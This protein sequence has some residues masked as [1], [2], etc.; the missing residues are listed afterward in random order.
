MFQPGNCAILQGPVAGAAGSKGFKPSFL[1]RKVTRA[2]PNRHGARRRK[3][4]AR[5]VSG[6][7]LAPNVKRNIPPTRRRSI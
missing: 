3:V 6:F 2:K 7:S 4:V 1:R 5:T